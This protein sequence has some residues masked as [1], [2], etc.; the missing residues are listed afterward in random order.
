[1]AN[2]RRRWQQR[3]E[4][5]ETWG[6]HRQKCLLGGGLLLAAGLY[7][8]GGVWP[9]WLRGIA[10]AAFL[11]P[12]GVLDY[13]YGMI[14]DRLLLPMALTGLALF[15]SRSLS[16]I[17]GSVALGSVILL[18]LRWATRGGVGGGDI[19]FMAALGCWFPWPMILWTL[20][21]AFVAGGMVA[22]ALLVSGQRHRRDAIPFGPFLAGSALAVFLLGDGLTA[23]YRGFFYG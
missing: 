5:S 14:F 8:F 16:E 23:W 1:M 17:L 2:T 21:L 22:A 3:T 19:K 7:A 15:G 20:L 4:P 9:R 18:F 11:L 13:R 10:L 12:V 6:K